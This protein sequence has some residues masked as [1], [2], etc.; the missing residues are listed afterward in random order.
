MHETPV[1]FC[2]CGNCRVQQKILFLMD[3]AIHRHLFH[4]TENALRG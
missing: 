3:E 4:T 2:W 1:G